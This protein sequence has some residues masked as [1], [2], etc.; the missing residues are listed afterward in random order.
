MAEKP[1]MFT[2]L[3]DERIIIFQE[4]ARNRIAGRPSVKTPPSRKE[5][6]SP[7]VNILNRF[8]G[9]LTNGFEAPRPVACFNQRSR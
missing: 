5:V 7:V 8:S 9:I 1:G 4:I 2:S 6:N 3:A